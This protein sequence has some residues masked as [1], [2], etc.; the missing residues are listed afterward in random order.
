M[1]AEQPRR[2]ETF[3]TLTTAQIDRMRAAGHER[4]FHAGEILVEQGAASASFL[5]I[6]EGSL[7]VVHPHVGG[8]DL[9]AVLVAGEFTG[10]MNMLT[11][12]PSLVRTRARTAGR[13]LEIDR[14]ALRRCL[15]SDAELSEVI[16]RAFILR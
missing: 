3:P 12:M 13:V 1:T 16:M 7:E 11:G 15:A 8:E 9:I 4:A 6:L 10:E 2:A 14:S 5:V